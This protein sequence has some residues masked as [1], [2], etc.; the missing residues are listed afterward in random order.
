MLRSL[1]AVPFALALLAAP[2]L[3]GDGTQSAPAKAKV[4]QIV[5]SSDVS[6]DPPPQTPFGPQSRNFRE[7]LERLRELAHD[8]AVAGVRLKI[9][10]GPDFAHSIDLLDELRA[11]KASGKKVVCYAEDLDQRGLMFAT[12]ADELVV[13]PS[14]LI[15]LEGLQAEVMYLADLFAKVHVNFE[16]LHVGE[17]KTAFEDLAKNAMSD[18]QREVIGQ[19]LDE[20]YGQML[21]DMAQNRGLPRAKVDALFDKVLVEPQDALAAGLIDGVGY[22]D[23]FDKRVEKLFGG[24]VDLDEHYGEEGAEDM[25]KMLDNPFAAFSLIGKLL[26]P[27]KREAPKAPHVAIVYASGP[28]TSGKS[29]TGWDGKVASMGSETLVEA[30]DSARDDDNCKAVVLRVNSPGGS[31]LAS[32]MIWRAIQRCR[33]KK[34]VVA[35]MGYVAGSGGYWISMGCDAIVAQPATITGSIGV[36][37]MLPNVADA[38]KEVGVN[39]EV[40]AKGP[41]GDQLSLLRNG[42]TPVLRDVLTRMMN[43]VYQQFVTKVSE[44]RRLDREQVG[45]LARG[46]VW[47]GRQAVDNGLV[48]ELGGL[49]DSLAL[50]CVL[51]GGLDPLTTPVAEYPSPPN[52]MDALK[53]SFEDMASVDGRLAFLLEHVQSVP[54]L[55]SAAAVVRSAL[56]DRS[57]ITTDRVQALMPMVIEVH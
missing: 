24:P 29:K 40:V 2:A 3:A 48:D 4:V 32:D 44:G 7:K 5:I 41:H 54:V 45:T 50:A 46:R 6:E 30:L 20:W 13:P 42:P 27:P 14:G 28:I 52:F 34:P 1:R 22:E 31:A 56:L 57:L 47:T 18:E 25:Q 19:L 53:D 36:V 12:L 11:L 8:P 51:G 43:D 9:K 21:D 35:S 33:E 10:G 49:R 55:G 17:Y 15:G 23:E 16:V 39:V 26:N 38:L 37:S